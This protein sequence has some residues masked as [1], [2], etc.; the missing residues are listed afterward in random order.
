MQK[1]ENRSVRKDQDTCS[2]FTFVTDRLYVREISDLNQ[3]TGIVY[4]TQFKT[5][6]IISTTSILAFVPIPQ[7]ALQ[8][9]TP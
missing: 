6:S 9:K 4:L 1:F 5:K 2:E 8:K 3:L 7:D